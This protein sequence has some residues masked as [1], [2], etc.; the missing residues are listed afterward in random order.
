MDRAKILYATLAALAIV[1]AFAGY[2]LLGGS[3]QPDGAGQETADMPDAAGALSA[4]QLRRLGV[5]TVAAEAAMDVPLGTVPAAITLPPEAQVAVTAPFDGAII[6]LHVIQGQQVSAGQAL[7]TVKSREP[8][9]Y[10]A[11]L[12]RAQARLGLAEASAARTRQLV[13]EGIVAGARADEMNAAIRVART[14]VAENARILRQAGAS[15]SGEVTLRAPIGGRVAAMTAQVG[16]PVMATSAPFV[17]ENSAAFTLDMQLPERL[18]GQVRPGM[19]IAVPATGA[20]PELTGSILSVGSSLDPATR[21]IIAKARIDG[22][23]PL[24]AGKS[25]MVVIHHDSAQPG[26]SVPS[27]A[28]TTIDGKPHLLLQTDKGF[29]PRAVT[30]AGQSGDRTILSDGLKPGDTVAVS[31]ISELKMLLAGN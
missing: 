26:V 21:S 8:L 2:R 19:R 15:A 5:Q 14:D 31:G 29:T 27:R 1:A 28:M 13:Q 22:T 16:G 20:M 18:A 11:E 7:A 3:G 24:V 4:Q 12:A 10:G 25:V 9:Q 6:R 30:V 23:P 17:I